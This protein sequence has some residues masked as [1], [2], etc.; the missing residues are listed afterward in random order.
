[1][2]DP[3]R[4]WPD[5]HFARLLARLRERLPDA[6]IVLA[7]IPS[8]VAA[9]SALV[10]P[11][12]GRAAPLS[13]QQL[14]AAIATADILISPETAVTH[15]AAAF[16]TPTLSLHMKGNERYRPYR[17]PGRAVFADNANRLASLPPER[18]IA[19]LDSLIDE[20]APARGWTA[21]RAP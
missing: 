12:G 1:M 13:L 18:A 6:N 5:A 3:R 21:P 15:A 8:G 10:Q 11:V 20:M 9:A 14:F 2:R 4:S 16:Q 19:A 17:T 7:T